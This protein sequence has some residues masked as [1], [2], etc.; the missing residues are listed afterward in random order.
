[1]EQG[2]ASRFVGDMPRPFVHQQC[3]DE[4][5][6]LGPATLV[7]LHH[8]ILP[9]K[10]STLSIHTTAF[11][12]D[13]RPQWSYTTPAMLREQQRTFTSTLRPGR[14]PTNKR[15]QTLFQPGRRSRSRALSAIVKGLIDRV[16]D[17]PPH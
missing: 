4:A 3:S 13:I 8:R 6:A 7:V 12:L 2:Q 10:I 11:N 17:N 15:A 16:E 1:M 9:S 5:P 14:Y